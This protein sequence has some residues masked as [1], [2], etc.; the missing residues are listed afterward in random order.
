MAFSLR[1]LSVLAYTNGFTLWHY[2]GNSDTL[3]E[4][5]AKGFF[6]DAADLLAPGD[7]VLISASDAGIIANVSGVGQSVIA[8][9]MALV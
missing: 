6:A 5:T 9:T 2:K 3:R 7:M 8:S 1:S 4:I